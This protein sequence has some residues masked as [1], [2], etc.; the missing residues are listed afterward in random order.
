MTGEGRRLA[1]RGRACDCPPGAR[2]RRLTAPEVCLGHCTLLR[3]PVCCECQ[4]KFQGHWPV[5]RAE[6]A[7]PYWVP[8]S[9]RP[10][11]QIPR[12]VRFCIPKATKTCACPCHHFGGRLP[13]PRTKA[14]MPYWVPRGLR[15]QRKVRRDWH[16][17]GAGGAPRAGCPVL[18]A[19]PAEGGGPARLVRVLPWGTV[20]ALRSRPAPPCWTVIW[21]RSQAEVTQGT[22]E[23][24][25]HAARLPCSVAAWG[26]QCP[27][28]PSPPALDTP[29]DVRSRHNR[30]R[31]CSNGRPLAKWQRLQAIEQDEL[32]A[33]GRAVGP[34]APFPTLLQALLRVVMS[35]R[36][37]FWI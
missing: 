24:A 30:W 28:T 25:G 5:P 4:V 8:L 23:A 13:L 27:L 11:K 17:S 26:D 14:V 33:L 12:M 15:S 3:E 36:H 35:M 1:T 32:L 10:R 20:R 7:L 18:R 9:L 22:S 2:G 37:Y 16:S 21:S 19:F 29:L 34:P 31:I 6:A